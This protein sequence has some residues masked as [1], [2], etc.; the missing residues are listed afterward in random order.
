MD[1]TLNHT[2]TP[3]VSSN[4]TVPKNDTKPAY[5]AV[6]NIVEGYFNLA[7][8][9]RRTES[10][11]STHLC[12]TGGTYQINDPVKFV[13]LYSKLGQH[14]RGEDGEKNEMISVS[15]NR[16]M[17]FPMYFDLDLK[18]PL[19]VLPPDAI[20][21][22]LRVLLRQTLRF[23]PESSHGRLGYCVVLDK[24]G[25]ASAETAVRG[26]E[27]VTYYKHGVHVY[28]PRMI[29]NANMAF[30]IRIGVLNGL[31]YH[32][33]SWTDVIGTD[34]GEEW[35]NIVDEA[36]YRTGLR[37]PFSPKATKCRLCT[38]SGYCDGDKGCGGNNKRHIIDKRAYHLCMVLKAGGE[39]D[40]EKE[41]RL[42]NVCALFTACTVRAPVDT[43]VAMGYE[44]Y[45]GCPRL[46]PAHLTTV[47]GANGK[48]KQPLSL[49][50]L[51]SG[52]SKRSSDR[53]FTVIVP[54]AQVRD[55]VSKYLALFHEGYSE[56][57]TEVKRCGNTIRVILR[58]DNS[59][60]CTN[61]RSF[62]RSNN[63]YMEFVRKGLDA[64][65]MM[66]CYCPCKTTDGGR[67]WGNC[68]DMHRFEFR[69]MDRTEAN[70]L[71]VDPPAQKDDGSSSR[72]VEIEKGM[73]A[74][75]MRESGDDWEKDYLLISGV[76]EHLI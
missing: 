34:P 40:A 26:G 49:T 33:G 14:F 47:S 6:N 62:H 67:R 24:N 19:P 58:G 52:A 29:V 53:R 35:N 9:G 68:S 30:Q 46:T 66:K 18:L 21:A 59:K 5:D 76:D 45:P 44:V 54:N 65:A 23:F 10:N 32:I 27:E 16:T 38:P 69:L 20:Q 61:K 48:R 1:A 12:L 55:V 71:F 42:R 51:T 37:M 8:T 60:F 73:S 3:P 11:K 43:P 74:A 28:F 36:V 22:V 4:D 2:T 17:V 57:H 13:E 64:R 63:V 72:C 31:M 15:E 25:T 7:S 70:V 39:R 56:C 41:S 50:S 75:K